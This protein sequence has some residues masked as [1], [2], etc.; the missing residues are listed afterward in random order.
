M[1]VRKSICS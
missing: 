1:Y